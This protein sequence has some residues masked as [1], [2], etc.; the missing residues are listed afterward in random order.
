[1]RTSTSCS[2]SIRSLNETT[3]HADVILPPAHGLETEHYD[4]V[5]HP[6]AVR[7]TARINEPL[8]DDREDQRY[9]WQIFRGLSERIDG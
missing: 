3:R 4:V 5:F 1:M 6:F 2:P 7:N 9:D 8:F